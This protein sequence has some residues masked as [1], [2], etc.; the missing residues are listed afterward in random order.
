MNRGAAAVSLDA[1]PRT[2]DHRLRRAAE[3]TGIGPGSAHGIRTLSAVV[4]RRP[5]G[6]WT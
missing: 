2:L 4:T 6:A 1:H 3:L 5:S